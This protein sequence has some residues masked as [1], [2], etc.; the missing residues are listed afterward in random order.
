M[1]GAADPLGLRFL[2][3]TLLLF[4]ARKRELTGEIRIV[5]RHAGGVPGHVAA[6]YSQ[7]GGG[8][9]QNE[10]IT[11]QSPQVAPHEYFVT[12]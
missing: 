3:D 6:V 1:G 8:W 11:S 5:N 10:C 9:T 12:H 4:M 2:N 7:A